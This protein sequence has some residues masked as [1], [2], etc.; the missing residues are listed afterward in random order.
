MKSWRNEMS[1]KRVS[2][3]AAAAWLLVPLL[4]LLLLRTDYLLQVAPSYPSSD[5]LKD[6]IGLPK[7]TDLV[8]KA[9]AYPTSSDGITG[10]GVDA[11]KDVDAPSSKLSCN[12]SSIRMDI[13]TLEG[14]VRV[15]GKSSSVYVDASSNYTDRSKNGMVTIRPH[16]RKWET[17]EMVHEVTIHSSS[18]DTS[19]PR[20]TITH[21]VPAVVFSAIVL[22][23][24]FYHA[25]DDT[26]LPLFLTARQY[27][28]RVMFLATDYNRKGISKYRQI[29]GALSLYPVIDL[30]ADNVVRCFP[31]AH[32]GIES[33]DDLGVN[34]ALSRNGYTMM[35]FQSFLRS[36]FSLKRAW[37]APA[38]RS[39][40]QRPRLIMMLRRHTRALT[41]EEE[42]IAVATEIGFDVVAAGPDMVR[43]MA[44]FAKVVNMCD[45]IMGVHGAG[46]TNM[47]F[48]PHNGTVMQIIP[49]GGIKWSCWH[50]FGRPV[51]GMGLRYVEY[52]VTSEETTLKDVYPREHA[53]FT[54]LPSIHNQ[55]FAF[56]WKIFYDG[57]NVTLDIDRFRGVMKQTYQSIT[58]A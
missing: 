18:A 36:V 35:D 52:E 25:M 10:D 6:A 45:M 44:Q 47:L 39:L 19:P 37:A 11:I 34:P 9:Q 40:G 5:M 15:H 2:A 32:V 50:L 17:M 33:H 14:D 3:G 30:D 29:L 7:A 23:G 12:F 57:Q 4:V 46:L 38:K 13:C 53:I 55:S 27:E 48:L 54:D 56:A 43:D 24:N 22:N 51:P 49:W 8:A 41:N 31:S 16:T 28:G 1:K 58:I 21:D 42:A 26:I 20:C